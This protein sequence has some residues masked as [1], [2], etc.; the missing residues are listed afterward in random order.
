MFAKVIPCDEIDF[1]RGLLGAKHA[2][3]QNIL[4][5]YSMVAF[6]MVIRGY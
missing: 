6:M 3:I 2:I 1:T 4:P 5:E